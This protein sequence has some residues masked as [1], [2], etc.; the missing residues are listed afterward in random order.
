VESRPHYAICDPMKGRNSSSKIRYYDK[1]PETG[2]K[3]VVDR[4]GM[5]LQQGKLHAVLV[6]LLICAQPCASFLNL[7]SPFL[8][9]RSAHQTAEVGLNALC[10][11]LPQRTQSFG[12]WTSPSCA[13]S[14][15]GD[16]ADAGKGVRQ[17][18]SAAVESGDA[19]IEA[20]GL[21]S[22]IAGP[23]RRANTLVEARGVARAWSAKE[24]SVLLAAMEGAGIEV[25][26]G[27]RSL[28][29]PH[30]QGSERGCVSE[31]EG[32]SPSARVHLGWA[33]GGGGEWCVVN[34][35]ACQ[36]PGL[37]RGAACRVPA[38]TQLTGFAS[39]V[40]DLFGEHRSSLSIAC[41]ARQLLIKGLDAERDGGYRSAGSGAAGYVGVSFHKQNKKW[42]AQIRVAHKNRY[43]GYFDTAEEAA[44]SRDRAALAALG[45]PPPDAT[46]AQFFNFRE[47]A[48]AL[49]APDGTIAPLPEHA[50]AGLK[51]LYAGLAG[52]GG[53]KLHPKMHELFLREERGGAGGGRAAG[54]ERPT[55]GGGWREDKRRASE[56]RRREPAA[57][58]R[59]RSAAGA[60]APPAP[61]AK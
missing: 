22:A 21:E 32:T 40:E 51:R 57:R 60:A 5:G 61:P 9:P 8:R 50:S 47:E 29:N 37:T 26:E 7:V 49:V 43:L 56:P 6:L 45:A 34:A 3:R 39:R 58:R 44:R 48:R 35:C 54:G 41:K 12:R 11:R 28:L 23:L 19:I 25:K 1:T 15:D 10:A 36:L 53:V 59:R 2:P 30:L 42:M 17:A 13:M 33:E 55:A 31:G 4:A 14:L 38:V 18:Y 46:F 20:G 16:G 52:A 27:G 24:T